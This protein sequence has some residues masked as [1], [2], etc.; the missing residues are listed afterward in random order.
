MSEDL[1]QVAIVCTTILLIVLTF[2]GSISLYYDRKNEFRSQ[3][4]AYTVTYSCDTLPTVIP[5]ANTQGV[6]E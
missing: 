3:R 2:V 4:P 6:I 5:G 1:K